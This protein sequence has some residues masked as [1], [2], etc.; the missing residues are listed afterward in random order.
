MDKFRDQLVLD[1][2]L[3]QQ[4]QA[5][6]NFCRKHMFM[7]G[8][9]DQFDSKNVLTVPLKVV[10]EAALNL[11]IHRT[12]WSEGSVP[13]VN[14]FDDRVEFMNPGAFPR[15]TK[16]EDF[17]KRPHSVL[18]NEIIANALF[19]SGVSE[20]WGRGILDIFTLCKA[21][22]MPEP[23]YDF[24]T[25]FVCLTIRFKNPLV[26]YVSGELNG[27]LNGELNGA[28]NDALKGLSESV[29]TT[30]EIIRSNPGIQRKDIIKKTNRGSSTIDRH[31]ALLVEERLIEHRD[32]K[33]TGGYY[34]LKFDESKE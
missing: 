2:N 25:N 30:Y 7:S 13:S 15:G 9:Q 11:L 24:V 32:S 23:E 5:I 16:P 18:V 26:P 28:I 19:K 31:L 6:E 33:K 20:G 29:K 14:I 4:L 22:G 12:W 21:A 8:D 10:R 1:G 17:R 34:P 3:F 27:A